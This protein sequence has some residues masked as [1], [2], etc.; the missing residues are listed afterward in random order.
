M[1]GQETKMSFRQA[2]LEEANS[3]LLQGYRGAREAW[4]LLQQPELTAASPN[5]MKINASVTLEVWPYSEFY[6]KFIN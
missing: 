4:R 1:L 6:I 2:L 3:L 5:E